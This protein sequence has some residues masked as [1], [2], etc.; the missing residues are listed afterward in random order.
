MTQPLVVN[1]QDQFAALAYTGPYE[2]LADEL[3][4]LDLL[5]QLR[6]A[7]F[8]LRAQAQPA[9]GQ[10]Q[11]YIAHAEVDA[12]LQPDEIMTAEPPDIT[13][14][15]S[16][17][18]EARTRLDARC[19]VSLAQGCDLPLLQ[20]GH[21]FALTRFELDVLLICL[22]PELK[23]KYDRLYAYLQDDITRKKPSVDLALALLCETPAARWQARTYFAPQASIFRY[24]LLQATDDPQSPSGSS[25]LARFLKLDPRIVGFLLGDNRID[26]RLTGVA[27]LEGP[28]PATSLIG[29]D[30]ALV[31]RL[32]RL[33]ERHSIP[34]ATEAKPLLFYLRGPYG[35]GK[36]E[37]ALALSRQLGCPL[38]HIDSELLLAQGNESELL[39]RLI[40]REGPLCQAAL[41]FDQ[42]DDFLGEDERAR[43]RLKQLASAAADYGWLLFLAGTAPWSPQGLFTG[44]AVQAVAL[45]VTTVPL[46]L[47]AWRQALAQGSPE[48]VDQWA[49]DLAQR[50]QLT[51]GQIRAAAAAATQQQTL[52]NSPTLSLTDLCAAC[53]RQSNQK[54]GE[55]AQKVEPHADWTDLVLPADRLAQLQELCGQ[56]QEHYRVF[57]EWGFGHKLARGQGVSALFSGPPGT[58][59]TMAAEVI[60][61]ALGLD[62][63]KIDL[64]QV[65]SKYIG[66]TEKN[67]QR[68]FQEAE[69]SNAILFFDE[70]D[71]LFGRRT[72]VGDA[73]DRYA[74]IEVS[75]LLQR[76]EEYAGLIILASN[77]RENMDGAFV[78][79][80]RFIVE[81]PFPDQASRQR[82]W[83]IHL[84]A[85]APRSATLDFTLLANKFQ[86]AGGNIKN[87]VLRAAFLAANNGGVIG[88]EQVLH[89][90]RRE[91]EQIG[92]LWSEG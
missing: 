70:A 37:L 71:A 4:W 74:N 34:T 10:Q 35:V 48:V 38:L 75:Y 57:S 77:L 36:H 67:L 53:R 19:A 21:R 23:R 72:A 47:A 44:M 24:A 16:Q 1:A 22:A 54:L 50:F 61:S 60:A 42:A 63:Y 41:Y 29:V 56:L 64:S 26:G 66:E 14:L 85:Q 52:D 69:S 15:R 33:I 91:Y 13:A 45:P 3:A 11:L 79:R 68:I 7:T 27:R 46:R 40:L 80:L 82:I 83:Q 5:L 6:V 58:G 89:A 84:P 90:A 88:M 31:E 20:L 30:A 12:L 25:D 87:I 92:R 8:R 43:L 18:T 51:P 9:T 39:L 62:L 59:K 55:L 28:E 65:V 86:L 73:H 2:H 76:M 32:W 49:A 78:R 17:L 81:F